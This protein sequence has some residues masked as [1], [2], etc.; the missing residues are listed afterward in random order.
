MGAALRLLSV[1]AALNMGGVYQNY[2]YQSQSLEWARREVNTSGA[3]LWLSKKSFGLDR[4][5]LSIGT[6]HAI[7]EDV[8]D[9]FQARLQRLDNLLFVTTLM[10]TIGFAVVIEGSYPP[11]ECIAA[12]EEFWV[13]VYVVSCGLA[14]VF[15]FFALLLV[16]QC[17]GYLDMSFQDLVTR[18]NRLLDLLLPE[19]SGQLAKYQGGFTNSKRAQ[20]PRASQ[21]ASPAAAAVARPSSAAAASSSSSSPGALPA[22][23]VA[24]TATA[25]PD[26][27][28]DHP[29]TGKLSS[30]REPGVTAA[31]SPGVAHQNSPRER[32]PA[33]LEQMLEE[34]RSLHRDGWDQRCELYWKLGGRFF[35][36]SLLAMM[37]Q[38]VVILALVYKHNFASAPKAW[39]SY[40][41]ILV[42]GI[43]SACLFWTSIGLRDMC[44][45]AG[46]DAAT[47]THERPDANGEVAVP[48][49]VASAAMQM[50]SRSTLPPETHCGRGENQSEQRAGPTCGPRARLWRQAA[51][52]VLAVGRGVGAATGTADDAVFSGGE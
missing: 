15:P 29:A 38:S 17:K 46:A 13:C 49:D 36:L 43:V 22:A 34:I 4:R 45:A 26:S 30:P 42:S 20:S 50:A 2:Y 40:T 3:S 51:P 9:L 35:R 24:T 44:F 32:M 52:S 37:V 28:G 10:L 12:G 1:D 8:R 6:L 7:R 14:L 31:S 27:S 21:H 41:V 11:P 5:T 23:R 19:F 16:M 33:N 25:S 47:S 48:A 39:K 18:I